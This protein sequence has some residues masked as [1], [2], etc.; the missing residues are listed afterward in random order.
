MSTEQA[1]T[2]GSTPVGVGVGTN[3]AKALENC[4]ISVIYQDPGGRVVWT[5]GGPPPWSSGGIA[6]GSRDGDFLPEDEAERLWKLKETILADGVSRTAQIS[7]SAASG[8]R[9]FNIWVDVDRADSGAIRGLL[10]TMVETTEQRRREQTLRTLLRE[11]SHRSKN[12]LAIIQSIATQTGRYSG[13]IDSFLLR[14]RGRIQSLA[15]S[16]DL[17]TSSNWR[18]ARLQELV[19]GQVARYC[20]DPQRNIRMEGENPY[21]NPNAALHIGLA[22]HELAVNS[23]RYG[24]LAAGDGSV[25]ISTERSDAGREKPDLILVWSEASAADPSM[26]KEK[27]FGSVALERVV[28]ASLG[29]SASLAFGPAEL[30]YR[31]TIPPHNFEND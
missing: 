3:L 10:T 15:S 13:G 8:T 9:W 27:R 5:R 29:G 30:G 24:V 1:I 14:F 4:D 31:L 25:T 26:L 19:A 6:A 7:V 2:D 18:G 28:P 23:V 12:L 20:A 17:V 11:V 16:Q 21:F 22:L